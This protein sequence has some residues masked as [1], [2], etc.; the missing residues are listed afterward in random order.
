MEISHIFQASDM[1]MSIAAEKSFVGFA[2]NDR[3]LNVKGNA[4]SL[5][6]VKMKVS[7][8]GLDNLLYNGQPESSSF[9]LR[10][11]EREKYLV[12]LH[13]FNSTSSVYNVQRD[14]PLMRHIG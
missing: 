14:T 6:G 8:M 13:L 1:L 4:L 7:A 3:E 11:I 9:A 5:V 12:P 10:G 2:M